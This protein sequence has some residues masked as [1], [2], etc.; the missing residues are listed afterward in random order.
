VDITAALAG[1]PVP[2]RE[3]F[4]YYRADELQAVRAG[5][6]KLHVGFGWESKTKEMPQLFDM[7]RD[8]QESYNVAGSHPDLVRKLTGMT[9][10][11]DAEVRSEREA[12]LGPGGNARPEG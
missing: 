9:A 1:G 7:E 5:K 10:T 4:Y 3:A 6:W 12:R 8:P 11:F 2:G